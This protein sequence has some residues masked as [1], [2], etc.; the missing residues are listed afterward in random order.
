MALVVF[1]VSTLKKILMVAA[2]VLACACFKTPP[3]LAQHL[4]HPHPGGGH[5]R[6]AGPV[7]APHVAAP[8]SRAMFLRP[9]NGFPEH[10]PLIFRRSFFIRAPFLWSWQAFNSSWCLCCG[11]IWG[12]NSG[13]GDFFFSAPTTE[14]YLAPPMTYASPVYLYSLDGHQLVQLY[15]KDGTA[16]SVNDYWFVDKEIHFTMLDESGT[17]S[18][19]Q[20][21]AFDDLD[22]QRT[23]DVNSR[24]GFRVVMRNEPLEQYL[25][26]HPDLTPPL[27]QPPQK[28]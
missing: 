18:V 2:S 20:V 25:R 13:C 11:P 9:P 16:Y 21:I 15:L 7:G 5:F 27:L 4:G 22:A 1:R 10:P 6:S 19:E 23:I 26:D 3:A 24:R 28:N 17:K 8:A 14:H 12:W